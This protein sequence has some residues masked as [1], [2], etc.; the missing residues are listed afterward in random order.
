MQVV[1]R[2]TTAPRGDISAGGI[3]LSRA[4]DGLAQHCATGEWLDHLR[5]RRFHAPTL[6]CGQ[7]HVQRS[8]GGLKEGS[9]RES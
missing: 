8:F 3:A 1:L 4:M 9:L 7:V 6:A 2:A 5:A